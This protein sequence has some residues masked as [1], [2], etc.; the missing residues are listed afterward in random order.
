MAAAVAWPGF[1]GVDLLGPPPPAER[2]AW[3]G[4]EVVRCGP[5]AWEAARI[6]AGVPR[7]GREIGEGTIAAEVGL[8][9]RTVSFT[10]GCFTGQ[11]LVARL[12]ARG[13]K[14]ARRLGG[15]VFDGPEGPAE[16]AGGRDGATADGVQRGGTPLLG[17]LVARTGRHVA[18][19]VLHRRVTPPA[20]WW[21]G[22]RVTTGPGPC[23]PRAGLSR[24]WVEPAAPV[25]GGGGDRP[26]PGSTD[27]GSNG[28]SG[29]GWN[30]C[31]MVR[32]D[33]D[34]DRVRRA[35]EDGDEH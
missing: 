4:D 34:T 24:W 11:E 18:L 19:A 1:S 33:A 8:V 5:E 3:I 15:V 16:D 7:N 17:G 31:S 14:V 20:P 22:G 25:L 23:R 35:G 29:D 21:C 6:E 10:K 32:T 28:R 9:D 26:C 2:S 12:D 27:P 30:G 13:S